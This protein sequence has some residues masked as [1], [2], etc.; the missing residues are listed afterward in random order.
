MTEKRGEEVRFKNIDWRCDRCNAFL[1]EQ[2]NFSDRH[3]VWKCTKCGYK[4][5]ISWDN[6]RFDEIPY[7]KWGLFLGWMR[8][9]VLYAILFFATEHFLIKSRWFE[10]M[11]LK[12]LLW[13]VGIYVVLDIVSM[14]F[15]KKI[16][17]YCADMSTLRYLVTTPFVYL[18]TDFFRP[19]VETVRS[20][21]N[22]VFYRRNGMPAFACRSLFFFIVYFVLVATI[23]FV[24]IRVV[25]YFF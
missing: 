7:R 8:S 2:R 11:S 3:Y 12:Y 10:K 18:F 9:A 23:I 16:A 21:K 6:I 22:N 17:R 25:I 1:N 24:A 5:S 20:A 14:F 15:E 13:I 4:N 19:F